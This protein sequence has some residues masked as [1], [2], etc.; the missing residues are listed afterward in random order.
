MRP[1]VWRSPRR[2]RRTRSK[3]LQ[4][5]KGSTQHGS[6]G[7]ECPHAAHY[8]NARF[9]QSFPHRQ[10]ACRGRS[11]RFERSFRPSYEDRVA[12]EAVTMSLEPGELVGYIGPNGAG[13]STTIKMLTGI[14]VPTSGTVRVAGLVPSK[15]RKENARNIGV[16]FGQRSQL[17]WDLPLVESFELLAR[18]LRYSARTISPQSRRIHRHTRDGRFPAHARY[19]SFR[20]VSA[21]AAT[22]PRRLLHDPAIVYL[23]EPTIG[24]DVVAKEA[25]REFIARIN[26]ERGTTIILTTHDLGRRRAP[27]P[28]NRPHRS[29]H[30]YL[31]RRR[32]S[33]QER[34]RPVPHAR[35]F[36]FREPVTDARSW[37]APN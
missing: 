24:L 29:R 30:D 12:V 22:S 4:S 9:A 27:L 25:I 10:T 14:L 31:R 32:R 16:V 11:A 23:D 37:T 18:D 33:H 20:S 15:R 6:I 35:R 7:P 34:V 8:R 17:Y 21:C 13:K 26:A 36:A 1:R 5:W 3:R 19:G 2:R 28:A